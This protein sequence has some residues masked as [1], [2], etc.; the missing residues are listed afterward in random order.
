M[1]LDQILVIGSILL[2]AGYLFLRQV[3]ARRKGSSCGAGCECPKP[4]HDAEPQR[5]STR[6]TSE[7]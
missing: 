3:R 6:R 2:A 5:L 4:P 1:N 7:F